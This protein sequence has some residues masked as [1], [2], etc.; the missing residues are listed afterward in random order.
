MI[1]EAA[2][3]DLVKWFGVVATHRLVSAGGVEVGLTYI[4]SMLCGGPPP[5]GRGLADARGASGPVQ[6]ISRR[7]SRWLLAHGVVVHTVN[8]L[9]NC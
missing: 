3:E 9:F 7:S 4:L 8:L 2:I 5:V 1:N 6:H